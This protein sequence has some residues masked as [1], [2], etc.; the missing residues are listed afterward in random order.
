MDTSC[1]IA[2]REIDGTIVRIGAF[3]VS[4]VVVAY[5]FTSQIFLLIF[6][7]IDFYIRIYWHKPYSLIFQL[8]RFVKKILKL[9]SDMTD[10]G[11]K[12]LAAQFGLLFSIMLI[13][14]GFV[15]FDFALYL[16]AGALLV[17]TSLEVLFGYCVGCKIYFIIKKV[18]PG[19]MS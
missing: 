2:F 4:L 3:F 15:G 5:L 12:R 18:Y 11:S 7:V 6:L 17:C 14:E 8:S 1:P 16:T 9:D 19:F 13:V 10:A